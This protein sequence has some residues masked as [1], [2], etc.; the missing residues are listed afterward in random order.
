MQ[1]AAAAGEE[2]VCIIYSCLFRDQVVPK[3]QFQG[4]RLQW[5]WYDGAAAAAAA[6][7]GGG[8]ALS[9]NRCRRGRDRGRSHHTDCRTGVVVAAAAAEVEEEFPILLKRRRSKKGRLTG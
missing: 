4:R 3:N 9:R 7:A 1:A 6:A 2:E 8:R 5:W